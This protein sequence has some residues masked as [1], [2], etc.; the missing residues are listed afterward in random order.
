MREDTHAMEAGWP[1]L[2]DSYEESVLTWYEQVDNGFRR[3][4][5]ESQSARDPSSA[6]PVGSAPARRAFD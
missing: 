2:R 1:P 3:R 5:R 6:T 4:E